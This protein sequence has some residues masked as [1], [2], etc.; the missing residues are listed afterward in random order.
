M[1]NFSFGLWIP[2][3]PGS[4]VMYYWDFDDGNTSVGTN[5]SLEYIWTTAGVYNVTVLAVNDISSSAAYVSRF[6]KN[7]KW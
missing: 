6:F 1:T 2:P 5:N 3:H 4:N 7:E